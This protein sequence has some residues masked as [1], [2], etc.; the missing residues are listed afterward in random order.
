MQPPDASAKVVPKVRFAKTASA[1]KTSVKTKPAPLASS[2]V[3]PMANV[4]MSARPVPK[5]KPAKTA[6]VLQT[7]VPK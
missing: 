1:S 5:A 2:V 4:S 3:L 7:P 6:N